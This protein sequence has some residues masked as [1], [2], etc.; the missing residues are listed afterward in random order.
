MNLKKSKNKIMKIMKNKIL[1]TVIIGMFSIIQI[2][3][4]SHD[5][6]Q[7]ACRIAKTSKYSAVGDGSSCPACVAKDKKE[8]A[9]RDAE[10]K[11]RNDAIIT[12]AKAKQKARELE[13]IKEKELAEKNKPKEVFVTLPSTKSVI[14]KNAPIK[15]NADANDENMLIPKINYKKG[16]YRALYAYGGYFVN[17]REETILS[18]K[19]WREAYS[20][21]EYSPVHDCNLGIG[22]VLVQKS[23]FTDSNYGLRS[24]NNSSYNIV[25]FKGEYLLPEDE[26]VSI[27][28]VKDNIFL[29]TNK[30]K[31][32][33]LINLTTQEKIEI[34]FPAGKS[35][36]IYSENVKMND[37]ED[38][39]HRNNMKLHTS[40]KVKLD[41]M[42]LKPSIIN[43][44]FLKQYNFVIVQT[45]CG[46]NYNFE[47]Y[48][49]FNE[50]DYYRK[51]CSTTL[52][53]F[54]KNGK[55]NKITL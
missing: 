23:E 6:S 10:N 49:V 9:E 41:L 27:L 13:I 32:N 4:Q 5:N 42:E 44:N 21:T 15:K 54:S 11:R 47:M 35:W 46:S 30:N 51:E 50:N 22:I 34:P 38:G 18:N 28:H 16:T 33:Y 55:M 52:Y 19:E 7:G 25:N 8:K 14:I 45:N 29:I 36:P 20:I 48:N 3:A 26:V 40:L 53:C 2:N 37:R 17:G 43:E 1:V 39:N 24:K 31:S 12:E